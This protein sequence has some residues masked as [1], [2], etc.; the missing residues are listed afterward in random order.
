MTYTQNPQTPKIIL[1]A[2]KEIITQGNKQYLVI[3]DKGGEQHKISER[4][5]P[6]WGIFNEAKDA[7]PFMLV[8][9]TYNNQQYIASAQPIT[10]GLLKVAIQAMGMRLADTQVEERNRSTSLSYAKDLVV[11][12][13][14]DIKDIYDRAE[15]NYAFIKG[16][17]RGN[18]EQD[19]NRM[20]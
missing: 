11:G 15:Q 4:R 6:L 17:Q 10:E 16:S 2:S 3:T 5:Q 13:K 20:G 19:K 14:V 9:E 7:E 8:Y 12:G 18:N 1:F